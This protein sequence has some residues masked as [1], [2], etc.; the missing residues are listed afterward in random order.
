MGEGLALHEVGDAVCNRLAGDCGDQGVADDPFEWPYK[1][2]QEHDEQRDSGERAAE[3]V[4]EDKDHGVFGTALQSEGVT[5]LRTGHLQYSQF[6][7][8]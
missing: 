2:L 5:M 6:I 3:F 1:D 8:I 4:E 7:R